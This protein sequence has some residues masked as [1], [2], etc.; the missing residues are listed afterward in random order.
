MPYRE[1]H[2][3][4][5]YDLK[6]EPQDLWPLV[7][8]TNHF[9]RDA[10]LPKVETIDKKSR[11]LRFHKYGLPVEWEE[12]PFEWV[13]P[14]RFAVERKYS[15]GPFEYLRIC[16]ELKPKSDGGTHLIYQ[17]WV[18][19][20][21]SLGLAAIPFQFGIIAARNFARTFRQ[22]DQIA[23]QKL[24][25]YRK[26]NAVFTPSGRERLERVKEKL[27]E[28]NALPE[29]VDKLAQLLA[30]GDDLTLAR[31]R[32]YSVAD[33]HHLARRDVLETFLLAT[34]N[35]ILDL[36]WDVICPHCRGAADRTKSLRE[37]HADSF[38]ES[39]N[40]DFTADFDRTVEVT[41]TP[42]EAVR[43]VETQTFCV[44]G[45]QVTAHIIMQ[46]LL[47]PGEERILMLPLEKGRYQMRASA[48][49]GAQIFEVT[50]E[51]QTSVSIEAG[52]S[53][54]RDQAGKLAPGV[55]I[56][57]VNN[58]DKEQY[59]V[60]ERTAWSDQAA[61]AAEVTVLQAFRDLFSH[62][63]L[64]AG[65]LISVGTLTILFTDLRGSTKLYRDIGDAPAFASVM[66]HF[67]VL[68]EC[69]SEEGGAIIKTIGDAVMAVFKRPASAIKAVFKAQEIL[70]RPKSDALPLFLKVGIHTGA[71]IAVTLNERLDYFGS[72]INMAARLESL[73]SG[74][75]IVI[76]T[77]VYLDPE[78]KAM[79]EDKNREFTTEEFEM[80]LKGFEEESFRLWRLRR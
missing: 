39:C 1:F 34:R 62:E 72:T 31:I 51:G 46:Q 69:I 58:A 73:S 61:T 23:L 43:R 60:F 6:S 52:K 38:C 33:Y 28:Q 27:I 3:C 54:W 9:N 75:D 7:A 30:E 65:E 48:L 63:V 2:Y 32:P 49:S 64:R 70:S 41:F 76:S 45:P 17:V 42:N 26:T 29:A 24:P 40:L 78:V 13:K 12:Q 68:R 8:D 22:Y 25:L 16:A 57:L 56:R 55:E 74:E 44:G 36:R 71:A 53:G 14:F 80:N 35:G 77:S 18:K 15:K 47:K 19:P 21:N 10:G 66:R 50:E 11:R 37:L 20:K 5:E 79:L 67:D 4:W 59:F